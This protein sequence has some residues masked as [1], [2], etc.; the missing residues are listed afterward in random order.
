MLL[1]EGK[2]RGNGCEGERRLMGAGM[3]E[4]RETVARMHCMKEEPF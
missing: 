1:Y 2:W 4:G 3:R